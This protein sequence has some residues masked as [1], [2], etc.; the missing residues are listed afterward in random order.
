MWVINIYPYFA[1][2]WEK[3]MLLDPCKIKGWKVCRTWPGLICPACPTL[4]VDY[5]QIWQGEIEPERV[6]DGYIGGR[7]DYKFYPYITIFDTYEEA[8]LVCVMIQGR[9]PQSKF[10]I[11]PVH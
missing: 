11:E 3:N 6:Y 9:W 1:L 5:L 10:M 7:T 4:L 2:L 8:D